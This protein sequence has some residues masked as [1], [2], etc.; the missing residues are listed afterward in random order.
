MTE[1]DTPRARPRRPFARLP[2]AALAAC[3]ALA[4]PPVAQAQSGPSAIGRLPTIL[5]LPGIGPESAPEAPPGGVPGGPVMAGPGAGAGAARQVKDLA[6][7]LKDQPKPFAGATTP[8]LT[9]ASAQ[10]FIQHN[11]RELGIDGKAGAFQLSEARQTLSGRHLSLEQRL[12]GLRILDGHIQIKVGD[13]GAVQSVTRNIVSVPVAK[14]AG[15]MRSALLDE[16]AAREIAWQDLGVAGELLEPPQ[17]EK[18]YLNENNVLTLVYVVRLAVSRPMGYWEHR[19]DAVSGRIISRVDR[20]VQEAKRAPQ[21]APG[22]QGPGPR[23]MAAPLVSSAAALQNLAQRQQAEAGVELA[24]K[25][26]VLGAAP[27]L[28]FDSNPMTALADATLQNTDAASRFDA[29]YVKVTLQQLRRSNG[30][31]RLNGALVRIDD[32]EPGE[33]GAKRPP[34]TAAVEWSARRGDNAFNDVMSYYHLHNSLA[35]LKKI[36]YDGSRELFRKPIA[37]DTD[38]VNGDDNSHYVPGSDRLAFGHGCV[39]DNEDSDV[40]L[41]ELGHAIHY[42]VNPEW[43]GG[44]SGAVGEGFGDY[45]AA[46]SRMRMKDGWAFQPGKVFVW[47]GIDACWGGRRVDRKEARYDPARTYGAHEPVGAFVSDEL[48]ST[49]LI[50]ALLELTAGGAAIGTVDAVI[51]EG[52]AGIGSNFTMRSL[53]LKT[54]EQARQLYPDQPHAAVFEKHFKLHGIVK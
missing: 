33:N 25:A 3:V 50:G 15:V 4:W 48:W 6:P 11:A 37:V 41:H 16:K 34:S 36:G 31:F 47:D 46:S 8:A 42:H 23:T 30:L 29:A 53:A 14:A 52:M 17:V 22:P 28:V 13:D 21:V 44:D 32:F 40:I 49:P 5:Y 35:Y 54:I 43:G 45:W 20:R 10:S 1:L 38:G 18:A 27:A 2:L 24:Q 26:A 39:D 9:A 7:L 19:I 12:N 51:L